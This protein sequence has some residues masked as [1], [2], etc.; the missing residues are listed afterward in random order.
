VHASALVLLA[1]LDGNTRRYSAAHSKCSAYGW[2]N[3]ALW[4]AK[5]AEADDWADG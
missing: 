1:V 2:R 5:R 3:V 4:F